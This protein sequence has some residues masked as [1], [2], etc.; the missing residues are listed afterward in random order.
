MIKDIRQLS[1]YARDKN[2]LKELKINDF[3]SSIISCIIIYPNNSA[4]E[5][6]NNRKLKETEME[7]FIQF[8]KCGIK[9]PVK[10]LI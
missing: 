8:Y 7:Q 10:K 5:N 1:A 6:F 9:L 2:I 3:T 4:E